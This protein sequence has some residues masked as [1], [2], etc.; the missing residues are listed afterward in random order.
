MLQLSSLDKLSRLIHNSLTMDNI[1][2]LPDKLIYEIKEDEYI[3]N[4]TILEECLQNTLELMEIKGKVEKTNDN[5]W[6][7]HGL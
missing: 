2:Q 1:S 3:V 6:R 7:I 5:K 4:Q